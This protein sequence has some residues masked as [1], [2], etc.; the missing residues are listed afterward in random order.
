MAYLRAIQ[1]NEK[2]IKSVNEILLSF[3]SG[4]D[5]NANNS[6]D[7]AFIE[8]VFLDEKNIKQ[9][10]FYWGLGLSDQFSTPIAP[11]WYWT[12]NGALQF[13]KFS[14]A[15]FVNREY[16][17]LGTGISWLTDNHSVTSNLQYAAT[18][19]KG[20]PSFGIFDTTDLLQEMASISVNYQYKTKAQVTWGVS[21]RLA[22]ARHDDA[23]KIRDMDQLMWTV[24]YSMPIAKSNRLTLKASLGE[25]SPENPLSIYEND[26]SGVSAAY[27]HSIANDLTL[28]GNFD[29]QQVNYADDKPHIGQLRD[30][31]IRH[32]NIGLNKLFDDRWSLLSRLTYTHHESSIDLFNYYKSS[33][34]FILSYRI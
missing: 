4:Y 12:A 31:T 6:T 24:H 28:I 14:S 30:D 9:G 10:S 34:D 5:N 32:A 8:G 2:Q 16:A 33:V 3:I 7:Q 27:L 13:R 17:S 11:D 18:E 1:K 15:Q 29:F 20:A 26:R 19:V 21:G 22:R 25:D 23:L